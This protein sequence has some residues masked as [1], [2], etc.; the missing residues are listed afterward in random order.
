MSQLTADMPLKDLTIWL[1]KHA[2][3]TL[4]HTARGEE[5]A[6]CDLDKI[7]H[8]STSQLG[9]RLHETAWTKDHLDHQKQWLLESNNLD[10]ELSVITLTNQP[11]ATTSP[12]IAPPPCDTKGGITETRPSLAPCSDGD[13]LIGNI[14][15]SVTNNLYQ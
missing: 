3:V 1:G 13:V 8:S 4:T 9:K 10:S 5:Y 2:G 12:A 7:A 6:A 11:S 15:D 14:D